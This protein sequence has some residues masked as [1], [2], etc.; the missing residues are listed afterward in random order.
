FFGLGKT[1]E[2]GPV[3]PGATR[4]SKDNRALLQEALFDLLECKRLLDQVR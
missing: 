2:D 1:E 3:A 4:L